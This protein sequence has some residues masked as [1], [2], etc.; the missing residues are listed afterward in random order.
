MEPTHDALRRAAALQQAGDYRAAAALLERAGA[1]GQARQLYQDL[2][3][4]PA[5]G[6]AARRQGDDLGALDLY[7][8]GNRLDEAESIRRELMAELSEDLP[9]AL[10]LFEA[11]G[12]Y[13]QAAELAE[14]I[15]QL[16]RAAA[17]YQQ[18]SSHLRA[19]VLLE[20]LGRQRQAGEAYEALL[21]GDDSVVAAN[22]GLGRVLQRFGRHREAIALLVKALRDPSQRQEAGRRVAYAFF[23]LGLLE[24]GRAALER[25]GLE[26]G[27]DP[28]A[29]MRV[30]EDEVQQAARDAAAD[31]AAG[32]ALE[33]RYR[34]ERPLGGRFGSTWQGRDLLSNQA[35]VIRFYPGDAEENEAFFAEM[36]QISRAACRGH[37]RVLEINRA[38][39]FVVNQ[40]L[41]GDTLRR[42][43]RLDPPLKVNQCRGVT[44]Q[45]LEAI[46]AAHQVG[47]LH[48]ALSTTCLRLMPGGAILVDD[49]GAR[50]LEKRMATR[51][52]GPESAF[53][54]RAPE[55]NLGRQANFSADLYSVA[56]ILYRCLQGQ[57]PSLGG[58]AQGWEGWPEPFAGFFSRALAPDP[59]DRHLSHEM[60]RRDLQSLP[61][62]AVGQRLVPRAQEPADQETAQQGPRFLPAQPPR[63]G[64][65][66]QAQDTLLDRSVRLLRLPPEGQRPMQLI[67]RLHV[68]AGPEQPI[69]Q[70]ILR[71][72]H[73]ESA[74]ILEDIQGTPLERALPLRGVSIDLLL[75]AVDALAHSLAAAHLG[76]VG[77]GTVAR[78]RVLWSGRGLRLLIESSLLQ[79]N[80]QEGERIL[81]DTVGFWD[82]TCALLRPDHS[83]RPG[84]STLVELLLQQGHIAPAEAQALLQSAHGVTDRTMAPWPAWLAE[85]R[86]AV[87]AQ[88]VRRVVQERLE[89]VG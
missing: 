4:Y 80:S 89:H 78:D 83:L 13:L 41:E 42:R 88:E 87:E 35:V 64:S 48:G 16:A 86:R 18:A 76:G 32:G 84:P 81:A 29:L 65:A 25:A 82:I 43:L 12:Y 2:F 10:A 9:E 15:G 28:E 74:L 72:D 46:T 56:A 53:A 77:I 45:L 70:D 47:V 55:L 54:Y 22:L 6:R 34:V 58:G 19:G 85:V 59:E 11:R 73:Q 38:G 61:W 14:S 5:A 57:A 3:D 27:A 26:R 33:G 67:D 7:L 51:T 50:H 8:K 36:E 39:S 44:L 20:R 60:F 21:R 71:F 1:W 68:L 62:D 37:V 30:F 23:K 63:A 52:G 40:Y 66:V 17:L 24:A 69:L 75:E 31:Q 79:D 49:W